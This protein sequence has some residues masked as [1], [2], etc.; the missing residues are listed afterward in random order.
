MV[1][2]WHVSVDYG[3]SEHQT[4]LLNT[5]EEHVDERKVSHT[6]TGCA[7]LA[8]CVSEQMGQ[9]ETT[10]NI[11]ALK[12]HSEPVVDC[13]LSL[14]FILFTINPNK[15]CIVPITVHRTHPSIS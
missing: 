13:L 1:L 5:T 14:E 10:N 7:E 12:T 8:K 3:K 2:R 4:C 6:G 15:S 9:A 11:V